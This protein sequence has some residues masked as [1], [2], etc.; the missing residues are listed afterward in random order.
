MT[1]KTHG[2]AKGCGRKTKHRTE[3]AALTYIQNMP[4]DTTEVHPYRCRYCK[5]WHAGHYM[6]SS[7]L[8]KRAMR[9]FIKL[10]E[11]E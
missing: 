8:P 7:K 5:S 2:F 1:P 3:R 6:G 4:T 10:E 11:E 9:V